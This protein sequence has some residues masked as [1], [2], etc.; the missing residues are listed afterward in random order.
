MERIQKIKEKKKGKEK[1]EKGESKRLYRG[2]GH[3]RI[4]QP[5]N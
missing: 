5:S 3:V 4:P 1:S 2:W